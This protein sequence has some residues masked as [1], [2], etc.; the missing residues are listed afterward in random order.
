MNPPPKSHFQHCNAL[1]RRSPSHPAGWIGDRV[2]MEQA[3][4]LVTFALRSDIIGGGSW[5]AFCIHPSRGFTSTQYS[6]RVVQHV[7]Q[8][9]VSMYTPHSLVND[10]TLLGQIQ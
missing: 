7:S 5:P 4:L 6:R 3:Q 1:K 10:A 2:P 9:P 8:V